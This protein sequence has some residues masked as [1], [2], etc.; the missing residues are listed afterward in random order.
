[1]PFPLI[2]PT[3]FKQRTKP[4]TNAHTNKM[5]QIQ[6]IEEFLKEYINLQKESFLWAAFVILI[7]PVTWNIVARLEYKTRFLTK[8]TGGPY[9][10][11]YLLALSIFLAG[12]YR[13]QV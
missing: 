6:P 5:D 12:I 9:R 8:I 3:F 7:I 11:C 13:E 2:F 4:T 10:G 1:M